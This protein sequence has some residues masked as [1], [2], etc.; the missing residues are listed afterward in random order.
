VRRNPGGVAAYQTDCRNKTFCADENLL[1]VGFMVL[2]DVSEFV[3]RV[4]GRAGLA[5]TALE[6]ETSG[7]KI[8]SISARR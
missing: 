3:V 1:R 2:D 4:L 8:V 5:S 7:A 6:P